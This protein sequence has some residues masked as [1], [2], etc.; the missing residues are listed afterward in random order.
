[1]EKAWAKVR[2]NYANSDKGDLIKNS[3]A[4]LTGVPT[5]EIST[6]SNTDLN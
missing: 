6:N 3:V 2:G 1:L 5:I 4:S